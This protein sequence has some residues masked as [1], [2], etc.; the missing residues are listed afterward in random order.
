MNTLVNIPIIC[1]GPQQ[2]SL[3]SD[4]L[5]AGRSRDRIPVGRKIFCTHPHQSWNPPRP[6]YNG[7]RVTFLVVKQP[8]CGTDHP[9]PSN[10]EIKKIHQ[11]P[12]WAVT[13]RSRVNITF[14]TNY[15]QS[16]LI[17]KEFYLEEW[18]NTFLQMSVST[19]KTA[20]CH[21]PE[22]Y[23]NHN[24]HINLKSYKL[25]KFHLKLVYSRD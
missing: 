17:L 21:N 6:L 1:G 7:C 3:Y 18:S 9:P 24:H 5:Q 13:A 2:H 25:I 10:A 20:Q 14:V 12:L 23:L 8:G 22:H 11:L 4:S 15:F 16:E 19:C